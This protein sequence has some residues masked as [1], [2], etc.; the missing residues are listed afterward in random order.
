MSSAF[1]VAFIL[2]FLLVEKNDGN[3]SIKHI[4]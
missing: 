3:V 2:G 4:L 1:Q